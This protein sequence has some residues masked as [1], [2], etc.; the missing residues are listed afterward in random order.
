VN[1]LELVPADRVG[2]ALGVGVDRGGLTDALAERRYRLNAVGRDVVRQLTAR[3]TL[4]SV[5]GRMSDRYGI[6]PQLAWHDLVALVDQLDE[7]ALVVV[8]R[9]P[10]TRLRCWWREIVQLFITGQFLSLLTFEWVSQGRPPARRRPASVFGLVAA[11]AHVY[12][13]FLAGLLLLGVS[14]SVAVAAIGGDLATIAAPLIRA[15][16]M[17]TVFLGLA[18]LHEGGH[19]LAARLLGL[20][21][22]YVVS[23]GWAL[24][25]ARDADDG[26]RSRVVSL[27]GPLGAFAV[28]AALAMVILDERWAA[29]GLQPL[30]AMIPA[31][32]AAFHIIS[33][34]PWATDGRLLWRRA[35]VPTERAA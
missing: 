28:G 31:S 14:G 34:T 5:A 10:A 20:R 33:L 30:D 4:W 26:W 21:T 19:V 24:G 15:L 11:S 17:C 27:A 7:Q 16:A 12:V 1:R 2:L 18:V 8:R 23:R 3:P 9:D 32:L 6:E 35:M 25:V 22:Y 29:L 13:L